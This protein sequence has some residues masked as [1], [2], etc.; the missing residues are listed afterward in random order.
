MSWFE[1]CSVRNE[2]L[3]SFT[4]PSFA[5]V[6]PNRVFTIQ[7]PD[8]NMWAEYHGSAQSTW[9]FCQQM[10]EFFNLQGQYQLRLKADYQRKERNTNV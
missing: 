1:F 3:I 10:L 6:K 7:I 9:T 4:E 2:H 5:N 8:A